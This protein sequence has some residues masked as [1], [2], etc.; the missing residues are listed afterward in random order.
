MCRSRKYEIVMKDMGWDD[1]RNEHP[2]EQLQLLGG[3]RRFRGIPLCKLS[4]LL[5]QGCILALI[6]PFCVHEV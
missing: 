1:G 2:K 3:Q 5:L 6:E 4:P